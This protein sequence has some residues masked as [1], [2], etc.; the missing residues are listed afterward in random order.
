M[1]TATTEHSPVRSIRV[2]RRWSQERLAE[3]SGLSRG[4][5]GYV[6]RCPSKLTAAAA[7]KLAKALG[8]RPEDL[9]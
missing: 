6:E 1:E 7:A 5:V 8:V 4:L 9:R 3:E 2:R